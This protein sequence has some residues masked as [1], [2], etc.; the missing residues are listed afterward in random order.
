M[1]V[2]KPSPYYGLEPGDT[3]LRPPHELR[4]ADCGNAEVVFDPRSHGYDGM[5]GHAS[6]YECSDTEGEPAPGVYRVTVSLGF[7]TDWEELKELAE[8]AGVPPCDLFDVL[9]LRGEPI[10]G[11]KPLE[12]DY[13]CA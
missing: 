7:N 1:V 6:S 9:C 11:G 5:H 8:N 13:E 12:L 10:E 4:C 2:P 3:L